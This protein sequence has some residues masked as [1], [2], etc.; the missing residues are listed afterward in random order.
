MIAPGLATGLSALS[1]RAAQLPHVPLATPRYVIGKDT[2][3]CMLSGAVTGAAAMIDGMVSRIEADLGRPVTLVVTGGL[4]R[5]VEPLCTHP[6]TYDPH[7]LSKGL[8]LL[9]D[10]NC[11]QAVSDAQKKSVS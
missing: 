1:D 7:L 5:Y 4:A 9:F 3:Q 11:G 10:L 8:A 2:H 6:H